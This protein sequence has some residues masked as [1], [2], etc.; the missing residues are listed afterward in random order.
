MIDVVKQL[1]NE[2]NELILDNENGKNSEEIKDSLAFIM[3][4]HQN[5]L[6]YKYYIYIQR[7]V[8]FK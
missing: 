7:N 5:L 6:E 3:K 8:K 2:T 1:I 4:L